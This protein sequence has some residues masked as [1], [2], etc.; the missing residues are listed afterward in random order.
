MHDREIVRV[1]LRTF[2]LEKQR[3]AMLAKS[4]GIRGIYA[5]GHLNFFR[6]GFFRAQSGKHALRRERRF[7]QAH[8]DRILNRIRDRGNRR[9][10]RTFARF[11]RAKRAFGIDALHN[12]RI[13]FREIQSTDGERYS[14][15]PGF[16]SRPSFQTISSCSAW[17]RP[18]HT[19][20][21]TWPS[22]ETG[23]N[24]RPQ[25]CAA[26]ILAL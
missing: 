3:A 11:F 6:A 25:S 14:N 19:E 21:I 10:Q 17:P 7:A 13:Q 23:F 16:I 18:I 22:T 8:S 12:D 5:A 1:A 24:A 9:G 2:A 26:Q 4:C 20:P 15:I